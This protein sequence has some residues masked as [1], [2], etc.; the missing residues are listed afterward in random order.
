MVDRIP[1]T[2]VSPVVERGRY[3]V[4]AVVGESLTVE[5]T[6][7][8]EGHDA[9]GADVVLTDPTGKDRP[10]VVM[11]GTNAPDRYVA[12]VTP[13]LA[14][15]WTFRVEGWS[16]PYATWRHAAEIKIAADIDTELMLLEGAI[17]V[18]RAAKAIPEGSRPRRHA[19]PL[20]R[21]ARQLA[22]L[23]ARRR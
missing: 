21:Q 8:R 13:D 22:T 12:T 16:H 2:D 9:L 14:G 15:A 5:A 18:E 4:K 6:V 20:S 10:F 17:V 19:T 3:P 7:F 11:E 23:P 1:I